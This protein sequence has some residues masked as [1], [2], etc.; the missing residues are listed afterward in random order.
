[1]TVV[2]RIIGVE[3][4]GLEKEPNDC[5]KMAVAPAAGDCTQVNNFVSMDQTN[6][7]LCVSN[8]VIATVNTLGH[9][10]ESNVLPRRVVCVVEVNT[11][12][13]TYTLTVDISNPYDRTAAAILQ[14]PRLNDLLLL[15]ERHQCGA[16]TY[17]PQVME[18][19]QA[20]Q[21]FLQASASS[22]HS[23]TLSNTTDDF[24]EI[25]IDKIPA[26]E[27]ATLSATFLRTKVQTHARVMES[28]DQ[29]SRDMLDIVIVPGFTRIS[30]QAVPF[31]L[32]IRSSHSLELDRVSP[33]VLNETAREYGG[34]LSTACLLA[35]SP[36]TANNTNTNNA[37]TTN[38]SEDGC[39]GFEF[40]SPAGFSCTTV[41]HARFVQTRESNQLG[42]EL[43]NDLEKTNANVTNKSGENEVRNA[44]KSLSR[45]ES[46]VFDS[47]NGSPVDVSLIDIV[48]PKK[49]PNV[50]PSQ[51]QHDI[52]IIMDTSGSTST[53]VD[54][55]AT[56]L[57]KCKQLLL[58]ILEVLPKHISYLREQQSIN[59][60]PINIFLW[61]FNT[62]TFEHCRVSLPSATASDLA[63][64]IT[65]NISNQV[66]KFES[67]GCTDYNKWS[68][69]LHQEISKHPSHNHHVLLLTDG[70]A[71]SQETFS[72]TIACIQSQPGVGFFQCD[73]LGY[74]P[75]LNPKTVSFLTRE[76][77]GEAIL[78]ENPSGDQM[79][80]KVLGL[81]ARSLLR[82]A[83]QIVLHVRGGDIL[84]VKSSTRGL[85]CQQQLLK[86]GKPYHITV[87]PGSRIELSI[88]HPHNG[89]SLEITIQQTPVNLDLEEITTINT[90]T[91]DSSSRTVTKNSKLSS[92]ITRKSLKHLLVLEPAYTA[93]TL[94]PITSEAK[95]LQASLG[96]SLAGQVV[97]PSV[98]KG[99]AV[100][101][102]SNHIVPVPAHCMPTAPE[103]W[104]YPTVYSQDDELLAQIQLHIQ[105]LASLASSVSSEL[106]LQSMDCLSL[107]DSSMSSS[108]SF[109]KSSFSKSSLPSFSS[110]FSRPQSSGLVRAKASPSPR[111]SVAQSSRNSASSSAACHSSAASSPRTL[112]SFMAPI[113][114]SLYSR[115][116]SVSH[117]T[118]T[119]PALQVEQNVQDNPLMLSK[120]M[121]KTRGAWYP[122]CD[123]DREPFSDMT[124][125][126][127]IQQITNKIKEALQKEAAAAENS[128]ISSN[129]SNAD[130]TNEVMQAVDAISLSSD[131]LQD[132]EKSK[133]MTRESDEHQVRRTAALVGFVASASTWC[134]V[135]TQRVLVT[136]SGRSHMML[137]ASL[138]E[139]L[140]SLTAVV[141]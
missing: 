60:N 89:R 109:S 71:T 26:S 55:K 116:S 61:S 50:Q 87:T 37:N 138:E 133:W 40:D 106:S 41:I 121:G 115:V 94:Y 101:T 96:I 105:N 104:S 70:G 112:F 111:S 99:C 66:T 43:E 124:E 52:F 63:S 17:E 93:N 83:S 132:L 32:S 73:A 62:D 6:A 18:K 36:L 100:A 25:K 7:F 122:A 1:M 67:A 8:V 49:I 139:I 39:S 68:T 72:S 129:N 59:S 30:D 90:T 4:V 47:S 44:V 120:W 86:P 12:H 45:F 76:T 78:V 123:V 75:W 13:I 3:V 58:G 136:E 57:D 38:N 10:Q 74:G 135:S 51:I 65:S 97:A 84:A 23:A 33:Q 113:A 9:K 92:P 56:F 80:V 79:K 27:I 141:F 16:V 34:L 28:A 64:I 77:N 5:V 81:I 46:V 118:T 140:A 127:H 15:E 131:A 53:Y 134:S 125:K 137:E 85:V 103:S 128:I 126:K 35:L 102:L 98:T 88:S 130:A 48:I 31:H 119:A 11:T 108:L 42:L 21:S 82:A 14:I 19:V 91:N 29:P 110:R 117:S 69:R 2:K 22:T 107:C 20:D 114:Q 54:S 95:R 24:F